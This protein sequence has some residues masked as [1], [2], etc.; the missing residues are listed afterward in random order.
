MKITKRILTIVLSLALVVGGLYLVAPKDTSAAT[1][2]AITAPKTDSIKAA[3]PIDITWEDANSMKQVASYDVF[4]DGKLE[5][6]TT[7]TKYEFYTT[8]VNFHKVWIRANFKDGSNHYT[9]TIRFG[10]TKKGLGTETGMGQNNIKTKEMG[11]GWYYNWGRGAINTD[12]YKDLEYVPMVWGDTNANT[13]KSKMETAINQGSKHM[14]GFNEPDMDWS[15]GG[16]N[17]ETSTAI[18]LWPNFTQYMDRIR[19]GSPAYAIWGSG[20]KMVQFMAGVEN[21]VDFVCLHCYPADW[22]GGKSMADWFIQSVVKD[23]YNRYHKPIWI[24]EYSTSGNGIT[25]EGTA[26]FIENLFP[27]LDELEYVERH[28]WFSFNS[29]SFGGGLYNYS[30]GELSKSGQMFADKGN[31]ETDYVAG[32]EVNPRDPYETTTPRPTT[33]PTTTLK[34]YSDIEANIDVPQDEWGKFGNY[35][36][37]TGTWEGSNTAKAGVDPKDPSHIVV[38]RTNDTYTS[39]WLTQVKLELPGLDPNEEYTYEWPIVSKVKQGTLVSSN[40]EDG[41]NNRTYLNGQDQKL[42]G[43]TEVSSEGVPQIVVGLGWINSTNQISFYMPIVK[44]KYGN[45]VYPKELPTT[46]APTTA[47]V[48]KKPTVKPTAKPTAKIK[49]PGKAKIKS[50]KNKKK[51]KIKLS[52]KK[53]KGV[54]GYHIRYSDSKKFDG[55]WE[56]Y[57]KKVKVTLKK[58]DKGTKYYIKARAYKKVNKTI[59]Y[60]K[61]SKKKK[62]KVKK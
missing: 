25:Q 18:N 53:M 57:T 3:G 47:P 34:P 21:N 40:G 8:K 20:S 31:P 23:A 41:D 46:V 56:K 36:V 2:F 6:N 12:K 10:V 14:L 27:A 48:T 19:V 45:R 43:K 59:V 49:K 58:L 55:Y 54:T 52:L 17:M 9:R 29:A 13:I 42:T 32:P 15:G 16:C 11:L 51:R 33:P 5:K 28:A 39:A 50:A 22:N 4:V 62:V 37:Y 61:W 38:K 30:T 26:S 24:T 7:A 1:D 35:G 60:G 44:D